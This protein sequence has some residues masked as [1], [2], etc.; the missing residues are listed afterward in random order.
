MAS[1]RVWEVLSESVRRLKR[2]ENI[3]AWGVAGT[4]A[5]FLWVRPEQKKEEARKAAEA[6]RRENDRHRY[7][8]KSKPKAD[9]QAT[10][11]TYGKKGEDAAS[12]LG[13]KGSD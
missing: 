9:P 2:R 4:A 6:L 3:A 8:E 1:S 10:G 5:Y 11:L 7:I 12:S 13:S